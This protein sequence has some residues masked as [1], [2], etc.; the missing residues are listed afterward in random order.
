MSL[1]KGSNGKKFIEE[2]FSMNASAKNFIRILDS[3]VK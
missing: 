2:T 1:E 3:Y